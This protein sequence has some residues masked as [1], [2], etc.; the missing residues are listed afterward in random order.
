MS[1]APGLDGDPESAADAERARRLLEAVNAA[2]GT[3]SSLSALT[4]PLAL[5]YLD[6]LAR[7]IPTL[8]PEAGVQIVSRAYVAHMVTEDAPGAFGASEV[9]LVDLPPP[10]RGRPPQDLLTRVV[11]A[12]RRRFPRIRAVPEPVWDAFVGDLTRRV[13]DRTP[14][15]DPADLLAPAV[16]DGLARFG[17]VLRQVDVRYGLQPEVT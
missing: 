3:V 1:T 14:D 7:P 12:T 11:K 15:A 5:Q 13:H 4:A 2:M 17:W 8:T 6:R 10:R 16:V 9:P